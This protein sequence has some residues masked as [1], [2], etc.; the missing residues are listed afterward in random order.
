VFSI[1]SQVVDALFLPQVFGCGNW[2][3]NQNNSSTD[4][5]V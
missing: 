1:S 2:F 4:D 3:L 5:S